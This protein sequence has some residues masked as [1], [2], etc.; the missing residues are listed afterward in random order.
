MPFQ[1]RHEPQIHTHVGFGRTF[2]HVKVLVSMTNAFQSASKKALSEPDT[3]CTQ[4]DVSLP[5]ESQVS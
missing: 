5:P 1:P 2:G 3:N 4:M